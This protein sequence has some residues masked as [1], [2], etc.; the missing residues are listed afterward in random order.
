MRGKVLLRGNEMFVKNLAKAIAFILL[1]IVIYLL[2]YIG[3]SIILGIVLSFIAVLNGS[4]A[5]TGI[6]DSLISSQ[7]QKFLIPIMI[8]GNIVTIGL[9][10]L[11][12]LGRKEKFSKYVGFRKI[13]I[14]DAALIIAFGG[15]LNI[16]IIGLVDLAIMYL[17]IGKQL[18]EYQNMMEPMMK[19]GFLPIL[20][21]VSIAAP[22]FEEIVFRGIILNDFRKIFPIWLAILTQALLF[23]FF[24]GNWIQGVYATL[25]GIVLGIV[26]YK[27]R[28]IW[29]VIVLHFSYNTISLLIDQWLHENLNT[30]NIIV[31]G[32]VGTLLFGYFMFRLFN[33]EYYCDTL[34]FC[35][36]E[37]EVENV[38]II[39]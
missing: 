31:I 15:F 25:L 13:K 33:K 4:F 16:F 12:F 27:Y 1:M 3:L 39:N 14:T 11:I 20:I 21:A 29:A 18:N 10:M 19:S 22:F 35:K 8:L 32:M 23:G 24:H 28:S 5:D 30:T 9:V 26:Y 7:M 2:V 38:N 34:D 37:K 6:L 36:L 17:P